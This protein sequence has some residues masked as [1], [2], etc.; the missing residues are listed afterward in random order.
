MA[1]GATGRAVVSLILRQSARLAGVGLAIGAVVTL[2]VLTGLTAAIH[3]RNISL[4]DFGAFATGSVIVALATALAAYH[5]A[6]RAARIDPSR[7]LHAD[8]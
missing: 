1:L 3:L 7:T 5:P 4:I 6:R 8:N 2:G